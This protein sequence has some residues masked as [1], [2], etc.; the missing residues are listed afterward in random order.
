M[1]LMIVKVYLEFFLK[2]HFQFVRMK[3][4]LCVCPTIDWSDHNRPRAVAER[5]KASFLR[6]N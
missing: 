6:R 1:S 5:V 4:E 2:F 3:R